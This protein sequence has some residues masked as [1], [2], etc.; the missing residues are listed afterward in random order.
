MESL[1]NQ[2]Y[3]LLEIIVVDDGS[4]DG[5]LAVL[6]KYRK[7]PRIRIWPLEQNGG[8]ANACNL[9]V[10]L[11]SGEFIMFA[12]CDDY[13]EPDHIEVLVSRLKENESAGVAYCRS[14]MVD[15]QGRILGDDFQY[16]EESFRARCTRDTLVPQRAMQKYFLK[17]CV[18][19]NMSAAMVRK[20][21]FQLI[22]G[23]NP[24]FKACADWDFW[25]RLSEHCDFY[26]VTKPLNYF[27]THASAVRNTM[28]MLISVPEIY[29]LLAKAL[30]RT[31]LTIRERLAVKINMAS[32]WTNYINED[33]A[34]WL[35]QFP[36][37]FRR[38]LREENMVMVY[39]ILALIRKG[40]H[41]LQRYLPKS[42]KCLMPVLLS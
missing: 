23:F 41:F 40:Y 37:L 34:G 12:E 3:G 10:S 9:G 6:E 7:D 18:V 22:H 36:R 11:S 19:P 26:Y 27:R 4:T 25:C 2:S 33:P 13:D 17:S 30:S 28:G 38:C 8:Y 20:K 21:H 16:R 31:T 39:L 32:I 24:E 35:S 42:P 15:G 5:S 29:H 14:V 1:V